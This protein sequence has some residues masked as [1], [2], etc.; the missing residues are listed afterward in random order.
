[1]IKI[2]FLD[3]HYVLIGPKDTPLYGGIYHGEM[4]FTEDYP[5]NAPAVYMLTPNGR[6]KCDSDL[7]LGSEDMT[8]HWVPACGVR[9]I[10]ANL[11]LS[12]IGDIACEAFA[13]QMSEDKEQVIR[14][15]ENSCEFNLKDNTFVKYFPQFN[16]EKSLEQSDETF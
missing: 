7:C 1:M 5:F 15:A 2:R 14:L 13:G 6:F 11:Y 9:S 12:F 10:L 16:I 4:I 8:R 3:R